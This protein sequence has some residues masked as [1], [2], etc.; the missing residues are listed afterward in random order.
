MRA[1]EAGT[2]LPVDKPAGRTSHDVVALARRAL[3]TRRV[4][5]TGTLDPFATGLLILCIGRATRIAEYLTGLPKTYEA[6]LRL[7]ATT[8]TDDSTG[9]VLATSDGWRRC[10]PAQVEAA[11]AAQTGRLRQRPPAYSA[12]KIEGERAYRLARRGDAPELPPVEVHVHA[13]EVLA[14]ELPEVRFRVT[15]SA[16]TYIRAIARDVGEALGVG[17]HLASL[18]RTSIGAF[19]V[20]RAL[21]LDRIDDVVAVAGARITPLDALRHLP[22]FDL[23]AAQH[24]AILHGRAIPAPADLRG[25]V[26]LAAAG[27]LVAVAE[28]AD[29]VLRPRK[30]FTDA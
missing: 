26:V 19:D 13:L 11:L 28:A 17:G 14:I 18:R 30:V 15:V 12:K 25:R 3:R 27:E 22:R 1:A 24:A 21:P 4:G 5:H 8:E 10:T 23:D 20:D 6:T 9:P 7:G 2:V 29:G 16:G